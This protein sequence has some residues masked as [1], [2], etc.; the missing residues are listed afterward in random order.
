MARTQTLYFWLVWQPASLSGPPVPAP[1]PLALGLLDCTRQCP[2][3]HV[4]VGVRTKVLM[5]LSNTLNHG[6]ISLTPRC[7]SHA[8]MCMRACEHVEAGGQPEMVFLS[9]W[10]L[11]LIFLLLD[12]KCLLHVVCGACVGLWNLDSGVGTQ[13]LRIRGKHPWLLSRHLFFLFSLVWALPPT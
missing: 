6:A 8:C 7:F 9:H 10:P 3:C 12:L 11:S 4:S 1:Q 13:V 5:A 2:A